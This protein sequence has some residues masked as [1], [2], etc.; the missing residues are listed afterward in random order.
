MKSKT[1]LKTTVALSLM[2][3]AF[4]W[5]ASADDGAPL[6]K[7][8]CAMCHG[9]DGKGDTMMGHRL[10]IKDL[11]DP[12]VQA[13]FTDADATKAIKEGVTDNGAKKMRAFGDKL[14]DDQIKDLVAY[15]RS[16]KSGK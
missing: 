13:S 15:V 9:Q 3:G 1:L 12:K 14:S 16:L 6:W 2:A 4:C 10:D 7:A 8:N 11:T 5:S